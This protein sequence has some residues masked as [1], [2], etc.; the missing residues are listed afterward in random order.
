MEEFITDEFKLC[1]ILAYDELATTRSYGED[2]PFYKSLG[3]NAFNDWIKFV[4]ADEALHYLNSIRVAQVRHR[5]RLPEAEDILLRILNVDLTSDD[6]RATFVLD[7]KGPPF[8]PAMLKECVDT[9]VDVLHR[10]V[11]T[12]GFY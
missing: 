4:R 7:H 6:Y 2:V 12:L 3:P 8:T 11:P 9:I 5:D 1:L 10:P